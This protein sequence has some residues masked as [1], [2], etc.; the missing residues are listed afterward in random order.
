ML[1]WFKFRWLEIWGIL[2]I[3]EEERFIPHS[4]GNEKSLFPIPPYPEDRNS[5]SSFFPIPRGRQ[6]HEELGTLAVWI[7]IMP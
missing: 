4:P 7:L 6:F 1:I 3:L 2:G 5:D